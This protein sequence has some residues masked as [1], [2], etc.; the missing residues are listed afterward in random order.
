MRLTLVKLQYLRFTVN[1]VIETD[2]SIVHYIFYVH[3]TARKVVMYIVQLKT[4]N[5]SS[6]D[7]TAI[8]HSPSAC[9]ARSD[10]L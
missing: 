6:V 10:R 2:R 9:D 4:L 3:H 1:V 8:F 5:T 7:Y